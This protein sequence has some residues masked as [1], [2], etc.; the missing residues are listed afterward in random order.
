M[1]YG[2]IA[3]ILGI[4][5]MLFSLSM[6]PPGVIALIYHDSEPHTFLLAFLLTLLTGMGT[7]FFN[8]KNLKELKARD[9]FLIV[10]LF[11]FVLCLFGALPFYMADSPHNTF[12]DAM[13]ES[14]SG[15]TTTGATL[16]T[17]I[18]GLSHAV[19]FYRQQLQFLGGMGI[20][21][22]AVAIL[23]MLGV[24]GMQLYQAETPGP[25]KE[26]KLTP[27][28]TQTAKALWFIYV[29]LTVM[30][31]VAYWCLGMSS[32]EAIGES[33]ST[34]ATGGFSV[35]DASFAYYNSSAIEYVAV[36]FMILSG[37]NYSL[38]FLALR[39]KHIRH[40]FADE[41]FRTYLTILICATIVVLVSLL[42]YDVYDDISTTFT[43]SLFNVV[44]LA[45]TTGLTS[46]PFHLWP[47]F[48]PMLIMMVAIIGGC[49]ASTSGGIKVI[50]LLLLQKQGNRELTRLVHP[51][52]VLTVKF[53]KHPLPEHVMQAMWGFIA[54]FFGI[55]AL[56][57]LALLANGF[58]LVSAFGALVATLANAGAAI[59]TDAQSFQHVD[60]ISKWLLIFA[61]IAGR[62]EIF[63]MLVLFTPA[64]WRK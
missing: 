47:S 40:Y 22:L 58:D 4:F 10:V 37:T 59:G 45:T 5:L 3:R 51:Q 60:A 14:V 8:R 34:V 36:I 62:L 32:F 61:M 24:G 11:W 44:S 28:I 27:R 52:A 53:G 64:F 41:E 30:C 26:S 13:F 31:A 15:L 19:R 16:L 49:A 7:W 2:N 55:F 54:T 23:P 46:G 56:L 21:V 48:V 57:L 12:T 29:G 20:I 18:D 6:L 50:R 63:T 33:F 1:Q 39:D 25:L 35:H 42:S 17:N 9:G 38:H 43:K